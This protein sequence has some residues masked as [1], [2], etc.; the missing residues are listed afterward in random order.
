MASSAVSKYQDLE[1]SLEAAEAKETVREKDR[2]IGALGH[3]LRNPLSA[4]LMDLKV[5]AASANLSASERGT[6]ARMLLSAQ[7][8]TT[9]IRGLVDYT[10][11]SH[12]AFPHNPVPTDLRTI[13]M[14]AIDELRSIHPGRPISCEVAGDVEGSWDPVRL[15]QVVSNLVGNALEHGEGLVTVQVEGGEHDVILSVHNDGASIPPQLLPVLFEPFRRGDRSPTGLGLGLFIVR[16]ILRRHGGTI[17]VRSSPDA[18]TTFVSRWPRYLAGPSW[19]PA[20]A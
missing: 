14:A 13:C 19:R 17:D 8:M 18:G 3:D 9:M 11:T 12:G 2:Q 7:Q 16:E 6:V 5:L 1:A 4:I 20:A 15:Q 10:R